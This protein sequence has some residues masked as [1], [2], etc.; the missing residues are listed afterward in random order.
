MAVSAQG[1]CPIHQE[2]TGVMI[3]KVVPIGVVGGQVRTGNTNTARD[4]NNNN[5]GGGEED[6]AQE[7]H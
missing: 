2:P 6:L 5:D 4:D 3:F 1:T 7:L